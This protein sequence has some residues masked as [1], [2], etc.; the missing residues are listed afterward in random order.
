ML[1]DVVQHVP[2]WFPGT[3]WKRKGAQWRAETLA[4]GDVPFAMAK[5]E[6]VHRYLF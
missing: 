1:S 5:G 2:S 6:A 4:M 3:A